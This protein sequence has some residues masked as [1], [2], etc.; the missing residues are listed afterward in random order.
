MKKIFICES[1]FEKQ[2]KIDRLIEEVMRL[3]DKLRVEERK[4]TE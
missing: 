3:K 1:C 2:K 4:A